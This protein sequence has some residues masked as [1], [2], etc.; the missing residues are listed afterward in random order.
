MFEEASSSEENILKLVFD[1]FQIDFATEFM[2]QFII[3]M[4]YISLS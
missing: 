3:R 1:D 4:K 2:C